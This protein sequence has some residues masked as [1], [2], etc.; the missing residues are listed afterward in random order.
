MG[1]L[2]M[3]GEFREA[4][5]PALLDAQLLAPNDLRW[6]YYAH[7]SAGCKATRWALRPCSSGLCS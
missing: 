5:E 2:L 1:K 4:A 3:A 7:N 6:P